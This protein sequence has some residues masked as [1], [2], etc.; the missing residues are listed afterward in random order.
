MESQTEKI[1]MTCFRTALV[2]LGLFLSSLT[3]R[4]PA[5]EAAQA[6]RDA[7]WPAEPQEKRFN[8]IQ[9]PD[10]VMEILG[11]RPRMVIGEVGAGHGRVTVHLAA[12]V[13]EKGKVFANDIDAYW[14]ASS[15]LGREV[16]AE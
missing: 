10:L 3:V 9:P 16:P 15:L 1:R 6:A 12:R 7:S 2:I 13:G 5:L 4:L 8:D 14:S 11:I